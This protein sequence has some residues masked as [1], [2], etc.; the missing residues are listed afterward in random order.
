MVRSGRHYL[1]DVIN[2]SREEQERKIRNLGEQSAEELE[3]KIDSF[4]QENYFI[5]LEGYR[6]EMSL[7]PN[8]K[9]GYLNIENPVEMDGTV[10]L[11][12]GGKTGIVLQDSEGNY[13]VDADDRIVIINS[14]CGY[15]LNDIIDPYK[16]K[17]D[18]K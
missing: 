18:D 7:H 8:P 16:N 3:K 2:M 5:D 12:N 17:G 14:V 4:L 9:N 15:S 1:A 11:Y 13:M 6:H 10:I